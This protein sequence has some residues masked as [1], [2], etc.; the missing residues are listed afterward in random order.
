[1]KIADNDYLS[2]CLG[3]AVPFKENID[4]MNK[5]HYFPT[6]MVTGRQDSCV[7]YSDLWKI[8]EIYPRAS[9]IVLDKA[10]HNLEIEQPILFN[11]LVQEWLERILFEM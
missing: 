11:A 3:K 2:N 8:P 1:L 10:G 7:G 9:F 6:L 4:E 5:K